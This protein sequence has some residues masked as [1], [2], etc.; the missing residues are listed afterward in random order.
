MNSRHGKKSQRLRARL[1]F[2]SL[3]CL[4]ALLVFLFYPVISFAAGIN[5]PA[6]NLNLD[7]AK[8]PQQISGVLQIIFLL[9]VMSLAPAVLILITSFTRF[10]I[11]FYFPRAYLSQ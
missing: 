8:G 5:L 11:V 1:G 6:I 2:L 9:T 4:I 3:I 10:A 7:D